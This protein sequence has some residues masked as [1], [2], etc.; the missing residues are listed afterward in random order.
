MDEE[1][2]WMQFIK[3]GKV[4][5]Y[6]KFIAVRNARE[7]NEGCCHAVHNRSTGYQGVKRGGERPSGDATHS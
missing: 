7:M 6:L 4:E 1:K 2:L 3:C 5:D